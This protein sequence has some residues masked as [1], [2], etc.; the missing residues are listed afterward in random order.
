MGQD[1]WNQRWLDRAKYDRSHLVVLGTNDTAGLLVWQNTRGPGNT[2]YTASHWN[3]SSPV[4]VS[5]TENV[6]T[7]AG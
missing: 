7:V 1:Q 6:I 4:C 3:E 2:N 5:L